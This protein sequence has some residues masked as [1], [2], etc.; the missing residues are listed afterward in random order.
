MEMEKLGFS[1]GGGGGS[2][3]VAAVALLMPGSPPSDSTPPGDDVIVVN[4]EGVASRRVV[5]S[6]QRVMSHGSRMSQLIAC[7]TLCAI[8]IWGKG[9]W[10]RGKRKRENCH[11]HAMP[12][13]SLMS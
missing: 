12:M 9:I 11:R 5:R 1:G 13:P 6:E 3:L 2:V 4:Y 7:A 8:C 10:E